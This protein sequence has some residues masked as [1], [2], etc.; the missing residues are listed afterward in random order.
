MYMNASTHIA[1]LKAARER[2]RCVAV[3]ANGLA[4][5]CGEAA[6][7]PDLREIQIGEH[8]RLRRETHQRARQVAGS[9]AEID[10]TAAVC[11]SPPGDRTHDRIGDD[12]GWIGESIQKVSAFEVWT[13]RVDEIAIGG[14]LG[15]R[16]RLEHLGLRIAFESEHDSA[17][18]I[19]TSRLHLIARGCRRRQ[20]MQNRDSGY[21]GEDAAVAA[22][23]PIV[24]F[25]A[26]D[27]VEQ[28]RDEREAT[29]AIRAA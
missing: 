15:A 24:D 9:A 10:G 7:E 20:Q 13:E 23:D 1:N 28:R 18:E 8:R 2:H 26:T 22:E 25:V 19:G 16:R 3:A 6:S 5:R 17:C 27:L 14:R 12:E 11:Q 21:D 4:A 29:A